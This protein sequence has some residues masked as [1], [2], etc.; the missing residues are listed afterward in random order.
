VN[1]A[2]LAPPFAWTHTLD[3]AKRQALVAIDFYNRPGDRRS[4]L[5]FVV[6]MHLAWQNLLH[7]DLMKRGQNI[8]Y[9]EKNS[10]NYVRNPDGSKKSWDLSFCLTK[11]FGESDPVRSNIEFFIGLRNHIE[12]RFQNSVMSTTETENHACIINFESELVRR[13]GPEASLSS[14]LRFPV[15]IQ[16]LTP[17]A[18]AEQKDLRR[19]MPSTASTYITQFHAKLDDSV[20]RDERFSYRILLMPMLGPKTDSDR[21]LTFIRQDELSPEELA[22][23]VGKEGSVIIR[24]KY[25]DALHGDEK[26]PAAAAAA[27]SQRIPFEFSTDSFSRLRKKW[28]IGPV[29]SG[30]KE[31]LP[32]SA[33]YCLYSPAFSQFVYTTLL[34]DRMVLALDTAEKFEAEMGKP[35]KASGALL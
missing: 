18:L 19:G 34:V 33:T 15:F 30:S 9:R 11:E 3:E 23:M 17:A 25:R 7:A 14:E 32:K 16:S 5:D 4:Y 2:I 35:P 24:E 10:R 21:A 31:Q 12:H 28:E 27:V 29:R 26:L 8:Y 22:A 1:R 13:F 20:L 6:H